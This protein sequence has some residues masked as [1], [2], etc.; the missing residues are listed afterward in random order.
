MYL[1]PRSAGGICLSFPL[2]HSLPHTLCIR[3]KL[4]MWFYNKHMNLITYP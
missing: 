1:E 3:F 4:I 2:A